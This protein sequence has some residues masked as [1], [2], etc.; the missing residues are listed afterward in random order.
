MKNRRTKEMILSVPAEKIEQIGGDRS[1]W[2]YGGTWHDPLRQWLIHVDGLDAEGIEDTDPDNVEVPDE[3][4]RRIIREH[5]GNPDQ[6]LRAQPDI[7][8]EVTEALREWQVEEA[9][10]RDQQEVRQP[11]Y[12]CTDDFEDWMQ[13]DLEAALRDF[14]PAIHRQITRDDQQKIILVAGRIG[15]GEMDPS[16]ERYSKVELARFLGIPEDKL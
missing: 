12:V 15:W 3:V 4:V 16:P 13:P 1:P 9:W 8:D 5:G 6:P 2:E 7:E 10:R 14:D 11:V